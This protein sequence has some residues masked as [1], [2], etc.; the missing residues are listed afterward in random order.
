[1][2]LGIGAAGYW[3]RDLVASLA[4]KAVATFASLR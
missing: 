4:G 3:Q 1:V 2:L